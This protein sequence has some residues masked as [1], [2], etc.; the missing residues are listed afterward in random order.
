MPPTPPST[1]PPATESI[2]SLPERLLVTRRSP[3]V[4]ATRLTSP[5]QIETVDGRIIDARAGDYLI[6]DIRGR[7]TVDCV[8]AA[9]LF[10]RYMPAEDGRVVLST[11]DCA[12]LERTVGIGNAR[13]GPDLVSAVERLAAISIGSIRIDFTPGQLAELQ[14]RAV[15]RGRTVEDEIR[16]VIHRIEDELFWAGKAR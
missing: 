4:S 7:T 15:K 16:A 14:A 3:I 13:S 8:T 12:R 5:Q 6:S 1:S 9:Q 11:L 10:S 2:S